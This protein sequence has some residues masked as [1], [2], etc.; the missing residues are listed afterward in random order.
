METDAKCSMETNNFSQAPL[1]LSDLIN[2]LKHEIA[3]IVLETHALFQQ[4][5]TSL[6]TANPIQ[7][8]IT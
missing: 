8:S 1:A 4:Q 2:D 5:A 6:L 3:T 7:P